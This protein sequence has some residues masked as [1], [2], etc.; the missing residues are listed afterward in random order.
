MFI[1]LSLLQ[2]MPHGIG[3]LFA[4]IKWISASVP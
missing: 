3:S 1:T 2:Q 4:E